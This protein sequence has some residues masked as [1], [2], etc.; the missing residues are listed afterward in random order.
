MGCRFARGKAN[1]YDLGV[2]VPLAIRWPARI[3]GGRVVSDF[4]SLTD[5]APTLLEAAGVG[6]P[7][8]MTGKSLLGSLLSSREGQ[9]D[10]QR[11]KVFFGKEMGVGAFYGMNRLHGYPNR[12]IRT[13]R[14][15][16]IRNYDIERMPGLQRRSRRSGHG[17]DEER[18]GHRPG[19]RSQL[20]A[21]VRQ[22]SHRG[23]L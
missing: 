21:L 14:F 20:C 19:N 22:A 5:L 13:E 16:Y 1:L 9:I 3:P 7:R 15:L 8:A 4:V 6:V 2:R 11:D 17:S 10:P 12:A 23:A 18:K